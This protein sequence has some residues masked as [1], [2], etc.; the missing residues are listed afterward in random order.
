M[1]RTRL[2]PVIRNRCAKTFSGSGLEAALGVVEMEVDTVV[3]S[4]VVEVTCRL[5]KPKIYEV[6]MSGEDERN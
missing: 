4:V 5:S 6:P 3:V 1:W 2:V